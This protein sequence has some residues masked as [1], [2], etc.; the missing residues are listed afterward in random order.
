MC[1]CEGVGIE[2]AVSRRGPCIT[3]QRRGDLHSVP[4]HTRIF[5]PTSSSEFSTSVWSGFSLRKSVYTAGARRFRVKERFGEKFLY[6]RFVERRVAV[7]LRFEACLRPVQDPVRSAH[8]FARKA[9]RSTLPCKGRF[10]LRVVSVFADVCA[11][12]RE[13]SQIRHDAQSS[14]LHD[15]VGGQFYVRPAPLQAGSQAQDFKEIFVTH[16][17]HVKELTNRNRGCY[18]FPTHREGADGTCCDPVRT[19]MWR[20]RRR[21]KGVE[22]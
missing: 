6:A 13:S 9:P 3:N 7:R 14:E 20:A 2:S 17:R 15:R 19:R 16:G 11:Y 12:I 21:K 4:W 8:L 5:S 18:F 10:R 1:S 22:A